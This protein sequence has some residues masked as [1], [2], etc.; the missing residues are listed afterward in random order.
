MVA[1]VLLEPTPA[2]HHEPDEGGEEQESL[3]A[4]IVGTR[5]TPPAQVRNDS[6]SAGELIYGRMRSIRRA[7]RSNAREL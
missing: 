6:G 1:V 3:H 4:P 5:R 7:T 2:P